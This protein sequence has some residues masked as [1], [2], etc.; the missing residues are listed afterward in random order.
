MYIINLAYDI[1]SIIDYYFKIGQQIGIRWSIIWWV[2]SDGI[3]HVSPINATFT[4]K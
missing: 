1:M 4:P 2:T 3:I